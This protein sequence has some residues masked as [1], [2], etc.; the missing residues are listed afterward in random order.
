[1]AVAGIS[2]ATPCKPDQNDNAKLKRELDAC[3]KENR[4]LDSQSHHTSRERWSATLLFAL[5]FPSG[6]RFE[7]LQANPTDEL[8]S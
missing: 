6:R 8:L 7:R 5:L 1:M 4:S 2:E 3:E